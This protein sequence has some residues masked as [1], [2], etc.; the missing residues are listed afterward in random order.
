MSNRERIARAAEEAR[1]A[2]VEKV[3]KAAK[4]TVKAT[5]SRSKL[6]AKAV[7]MKIVWEVCSAN[8]AAVKTFSYPDKA[9]AE[10]ATQELTRSTGRTHLLRASKV[11]ME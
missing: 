5:S 4:K 3:E 1:L 7:R 2:E 9:A 6:A 10:T 8:G 11:P